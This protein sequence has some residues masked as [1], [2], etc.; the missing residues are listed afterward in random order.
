MYHAGGKCIFVPFSLSLKFYAGR[1][2]FNL[3]LQNVVAII[4]VS[5]GIDQLVLLTTIVKTNK[6]EVN[7]RRRFLFYKPFPSVT[8]CILLFV[9]FYFV[10][11]LIHKTM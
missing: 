6:P 8:S 10:T 5:V 4:V 3:F 1:P 7:T 9:C 2:L 11:R